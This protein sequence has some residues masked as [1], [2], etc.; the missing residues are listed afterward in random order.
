MD[1][2]VHLFDTVTFVKHSI[3]LTHLAIDPYSISICEPASIE[4][5]LNFSSRTT[6]ITVVVTYVF[7]FDTSKII[8]DV[9]ARYASKTLHTSTRKERG[10]VEIENWL[11]KTL[12][13][14]KEKDKR[15]RELEAENLEYLS[16]TKCHDVP[17]NKSD[18]QGHP[19]YVLAS[20]VHKYQAIYPSDTEPIAEVHNEKVFLRSN[21]QDIHTE[22]K[23]LQEGR[24]VKPGEIPYKEVAGQK[25]GARK[26]KPAQLTPLFGYWQTEKFVPPEIE[27]DKIPRNKY[28]NYEIFKPW[29]LPKGTCHLTVPG[30]PVIARRLD[31]DY[32][33][34]MVGWDFHGGVN[35]PVYVSFYNYFV[36]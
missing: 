15:M 36:I 29:M 1:S 3:S 8:T 26:D 33:P 13:P 7:A 6:K 5:M 16:S 35:H 14:Y 27:D 34:A 4:E 28:G 18:M 10:P 19:L 17:K 25:R 12:E 23:W 30:M 20:H 9:T 21:I 22:G 31:I 32:A 2:Y 24:S 11:S